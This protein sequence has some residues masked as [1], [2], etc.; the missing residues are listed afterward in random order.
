MLYTTS[1]ITLAMA[2]QA[3]VAIHVVAP[4]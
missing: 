1:I 4:Q 3:A 2:G